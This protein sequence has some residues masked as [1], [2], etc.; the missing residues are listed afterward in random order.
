MM[1][2]ICRETRGIFFFNLKLDFLMVK[3]NVVDD[4][5]FLMVKG[6]CN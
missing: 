1:S 2:E 6:G 4:P 5:R 3:K